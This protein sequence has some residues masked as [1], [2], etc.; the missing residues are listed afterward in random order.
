MN[1]PANPFN[2]SLQ[3]L[4][5][6]PILKYQFD[7]MDETNR[8]LHQLFLQKEQEHPDW[9]T[10]SAQ[11]SNIGGW[12]SKEDLADWNNPDINHLVK[13]VGEAISF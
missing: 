11:R 6:T 4:Y 2:N 9:R 7:D 5:P 10:G 13:R 12:R 3:Q 1:K 8:N